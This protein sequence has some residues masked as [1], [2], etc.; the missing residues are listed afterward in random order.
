MNQKSGFSTCP[1]DDILR[2]SPPE[3]LLQFYHSGDY[4]TES[5]AEIASN[6]LSLPNSAFYEHLQKTK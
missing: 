5:I 4:Y 1:A 2:T 3:I 6:F